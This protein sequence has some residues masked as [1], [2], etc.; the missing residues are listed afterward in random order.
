MRGERTVTRDELPDSLLV[1]KAK[2]GDWSA[3]EQLFWRY[4]EKVYTF[5][6]HFLQ[7]RELAE[8]VTQDTFVKAW[9]SLHSLKS[10]DAFQAWLHQIARRLCLDTLRKRA[11]ETSVS[12]FNVPAD[13]QISEDGEGE[14]E[15]FLAGVESTD[16][17]DPEEVVIENERKRAVHEAIAQLSPPLREVV[18][19]HYLEGLPVDE[20]AK[21]L[22]VPIG[23]VLSRLAR[24]RE[25]L[26]R[27]LVRYLDEV[28]EGVSK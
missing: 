19:L 11:W 23:T 17:L 18:V 16:S 22:S 28:E 6:W 4:H 2:K 5:A 3:F 15:P 12:E 21:I 26:R 9:E 20:V 24:A 27:T 10:N 1:A 14:V 13:Q 8:D 25:A 7:S